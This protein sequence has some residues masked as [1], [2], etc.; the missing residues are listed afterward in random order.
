MLFTPTVSA[1][2][3]SKKKGLTLPPAVAETLKKE[4]SDCAISKATRE[5]E[6]GVTIYDF[7]FKPGQGEMDVAADGS[8]IDRET[9]ART[10]DVPAAALETIRKAAAG[11]KIKY[12]ARDEIRAELKDGKVIK[13]D[14]PKYA[15]EADL[16]KGKQ[17]GEV[18][19]TPEGQITEGPKWRRKGTK[20]E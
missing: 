5:K 7:E 3:R 4:C 20:E 9:P 11:G 18:V 12:I 10:D 16:E 13:L 6:N 2:N 19:V 8:V 1:Q 17:V 14:S 15:Y